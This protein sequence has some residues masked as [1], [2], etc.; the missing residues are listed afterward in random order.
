MLIKLVDSTEVFPELRENVYV[1]CKES[2]KTQ[3][4]SRPQGYFARMINP[5]EMHLP[6]DATEGPGG[7]HY[8][9]CRL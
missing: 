5:E 8:R 1:L 9:A 6:I 2:V 4:F 3:N 7:W